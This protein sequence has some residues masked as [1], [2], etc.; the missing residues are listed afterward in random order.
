MIYKLEKSHKNSFQIC[1]V[2]ENKH[3]KMD[4]NEQVSGWLT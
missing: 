2:R 3:Q 1:F 4:K